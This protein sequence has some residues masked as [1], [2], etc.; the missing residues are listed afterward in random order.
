MICFASSAEKFDPFFPVSTI[1]NC[2]QESLV[3]RSSNQQI[4]I[5]ANAQG[6]SICG[7]GLRARGPP[8]P[9]GVHVHAAQSSCGGGIRRAGCGDCCECSME[10]AH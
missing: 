2:Q 3:F 1:R 4:Y 10:T 8:R 5:S 7:S 9:Q 6:V